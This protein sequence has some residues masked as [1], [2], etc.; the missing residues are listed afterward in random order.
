[1]SRLESG[2]ANASSVARQPEASDSH[3]ID[4]DNHDEEDKCVVS[5]EAGELNASSISRLPLASVS[6]NMGSHDEEEDQY[7]A[8][9]ESGETDA[10]WAT[11]RAVAAAEEAA[12]DWRIAA[13]ANRAAEQ[14]RLRGELIKYVLV[15]VTI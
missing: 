13:G 14:E 1:M 15:L 8:L 11:S 5:S 4:D 7:V 3:H 9:A 10:S 2:V 6:H 12:V